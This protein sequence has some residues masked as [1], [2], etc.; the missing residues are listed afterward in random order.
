MPG[1]DWE[2][3][4]DAGYELWS[5]ST[6]IEC[7]YGRCPG[8]RQVRAMTPEV[9]ALVLKHKDLSSNRVKWQYLCQ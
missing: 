8:L 2:E 9:R 1:R 4:E 3:R 7:L 5:E 6:C